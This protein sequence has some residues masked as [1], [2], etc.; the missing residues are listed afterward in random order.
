MH[1]LKN[2]YIIYKLYIIQEKKKTMCNDYTISISRYKTYFKLFAVHL[3]L[4][5]LMEDFSQL[6]EL[7]QGIIII[8]K[9]LPF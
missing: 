4:L 8:K 9:R 3:S 6:G 2:M 1:G 7:I 5:L